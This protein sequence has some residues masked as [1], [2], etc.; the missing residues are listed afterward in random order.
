M[1]IQVFSDL[2]AVAKAVA[3]VIALEA[4]IAVSTRGRFIMAVKFRTKPHLMSPKLTL[5]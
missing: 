5:L 4:R 2:S 3:K 1:N